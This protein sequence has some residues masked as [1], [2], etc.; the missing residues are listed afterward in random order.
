MPGLLLQ[1]S[2]PAVPSIWKA[3]QQ[4]PALLTLLQLL[5]LWS[6]VNFVGRLTYTGFFKLCPLCPYALALLVFLTQLFLSLQ[7][8]KLLLSHKMFVFN[9]VYPL[10]SILHVGKCDHFFQRRDFWSS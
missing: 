8:A 6:N 4:I 5:S 3:L 10:S 1:T 9:Y 7:K 2:E